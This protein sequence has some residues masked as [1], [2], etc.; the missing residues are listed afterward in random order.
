TRRTRPGPGRLPGVQ[1]RLE[2]NAQWS[3]LLREALRA[4]HKPQEAAKGGHASL[5]LQ[6]GGEQGRLE[7]GPTKEL[8]WSR[9]GRFELRRELGRGGVATVYDRGLRGVGGDGAHQV[10]LGRSC[11]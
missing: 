5:G 4:A 9:L 7:A 2:A 1:P 8:P 3:R 10:P 11:V 6:A